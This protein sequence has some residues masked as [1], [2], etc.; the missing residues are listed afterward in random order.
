MRPL[1]VGVRNIR[2][3][4]DVELNL[5]SFTALIGPNN[6]GKSTLLDAVR[7]FYDTLGWDAARDRPWNA[8]GDDPS[9]VEIGYEVTRPEADRLL[10]V[11]DEESE[12][13]LRL[14]DGQVLCVRRY[15]TDHGDYRKGQ[16]Y[17]VPADGGELEPTGWQEVAGRL[18][19]CVYVPTQAQ[20]RDHTS[21][22]ESSPLR[23]VLLLAFSEPEI[24]F[25]LAAV[26]TALRGLGDILTK[27]PV[28]NLESELDR[29]LNPWGL[30]AKIRINELTNEFILRNLIDLTFEDE[31]AE[32]SMEAQGSG[33]QRT[34][35][36][37]LIQTAARLRQSTDDT[38][39]RWIL[40]EEPESFLHPAQVTRLAQDLRQ[41]TQSGNA[42]VTITTHD[43]TTLSS[44]E[45]PPEAIARIQRFGAGIRATSPDP[46][47]V[48][49]T[50]DAVHTRSLYAQASHSCF[51]RVRQTP[52][53][54]EHTRVLY[55]LDGRRASAFFAD[56]VIVVEG[57]SDVVFFEW[58]DRRGHLS[59][60]GPNL[61]VLDAG[62]KYELHRAVATLSLFK[63]PHVVIWD[64][65]AAMKPIGTSEH[66]QAECRDR[67][68][69]DALRAAASDPTSAFMGGLRLAGT[70][71][72]WL[73]ITEEKTGAWKAANLGASMTNAYADSASTVPGRIDSLLEVI[74]ALFDHADLSTFLSRPEFTGA[75]LTRQL[76][77]T[78]V[79][80]AAEVANLPR[81]ACVCRPT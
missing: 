56:Q 43:P 51:K 13:G 27:G 78:A 37:G 66:R 5:R 38:A 17:F 9:C 62:G 16:Y 33:V 50:L 20:V 40:F 55:D 1:R 2:G 72:R 60:V 10:G 34:L 81:P 11:T 79:D 53:D 70:I 30:A 22:A 18:G 49:R 15:L 54:E 63:I 25:Y 21:L 29:A 58:L 26:R 46:G 23:D 71:E 36:A 75:L 39:F 67:A 80:L 42:A 4:L 6:A 65:D 57:T 14:L 8:V 47:V 48:A 28:S 24:D 44:S 45:T 3:A 74:R 32:R 61:G 73:G 35:V 68:A 77:N 76:G 12:S 19:Q 31:G 7:L 41:L 69:L 59:R 64:E 52:S